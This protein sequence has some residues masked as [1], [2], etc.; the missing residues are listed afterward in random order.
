MGVALIQFS[1]EK[2]FKMYK[3]S[4]FFSKFEQV[5]YFFCSTCT[6]SGWQKLSEEAVTKTRNLMRP[7][8]QASI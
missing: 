6:N 2:I 7:K 8:C 5:I 1:N 4:S 3:E